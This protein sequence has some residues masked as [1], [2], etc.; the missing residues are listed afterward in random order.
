MNNSDTSVMPFQFRSNEVRVVTDEQGA[1][2][3]VAKD[4]CEILD[5]SDTSK[6]L[7]RIP[8]HH[9][10]TNP[11]RTLGGTQQM[12]TVDEAGLYRLVLRSDKPEAEPF[13]EW[14]TSDVLPTI[15]KTGRYEFHQQPF[16]HSMET[17]MDKDLKIYDAAVKTLRISDAGRI[18]ILHSIGELHGRPA[19]Y[20]PNYTEERI[21]KSLTALLKQYKSDLTARIAY[22]LLVANGLIEIKTRESTKKDKDE[23]TK[24]IIKQFKSLTDRGLQYG[25]NLINPHNEKETQPHF[26]EDTFH[27]V[28]DMLNGWV[29]PAG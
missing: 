4:V 18:K 11:I 13:M 27:Q 8:S 15:R 26:Y 1:P 28:F 20:L 29:E 3:F 7:E 21:T 9:K 25:K 14:V 12:L 19:P 10:G 2:W 5:L 6:S 16:F 23:K 24:K 22:P 17:A